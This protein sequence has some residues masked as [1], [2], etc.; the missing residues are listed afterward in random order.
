MHVPYYRR[1][2]PAQEWLEEED[3]EW[4]EDT[5]EWRERKWRL[6]EEE[7]QSKSAVKPPVETKVSAWRA[8]RGPS[9]LTAAALAPT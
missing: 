4:H 6:K 9:G 2:A 5:L 3:E 1:R 8:A 7:Q